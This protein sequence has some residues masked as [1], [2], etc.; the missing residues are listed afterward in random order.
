VIG[1]LSLATVATLTFVPVFFSML[2]RNDK[3]AAQITDAVDL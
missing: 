2:H 1:G 3:A